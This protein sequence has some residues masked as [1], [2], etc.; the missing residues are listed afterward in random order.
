MVVP[1]LAQVTPPSWQAEA[2]FYE[3]F[4]RSF[5]DSDG[6]GIGD[7]QGILSQLDYLNDGDSTT[8]DDLGITGIWLMPINPS[9][10]YHGYD[11]TDYFGVNPD[12]GTLSDF[13]AL[14]DGCHERG[15]RVI[16]DFVGNHSSSGHPDFVQ[17]SSSP[18]H[19]KR[20]WFVWSDVNPGGD[21]H[22]GG[23]GWYYGLF[24]SGM[25]DWNVQNPAV[26]DVHY[27]VVDHWLAMGVDGFRYDAVKHLVNEGGT[28]ENH[29]GTFDYLEA[30]RNHYQSVNPE[31]ICVG[32][33]WTGSDVIAQYGPP[34]LDMCFEFGLAGGLISSVNS[35]NGGSFRGALDFV[36]D[37]HQAGAYAPFLT[38]HDQDRVMSMLGGDV[39][40]AKLAAGVLL[41]LPGTPFLY[42]GEEIGMTGSGSHPAVRTP[43]QWAPGSQAGFTSGTPWSAVQPDVNAANVASQLGDAHSLLS[44]YREFI[45][46]RHAEPA[47]QRGE[48]VTWDTDMDEAVAFLRTLGDERLLVVHNFSGAALNDVQV[49][50]NALCDG[51]YSVS[52]V[53][54]GTDLGQAVLTAG[55][56][57]SLPG[58]L[59]PHATHVFRLQAETVGDACAVPLTVAV[60]QHAIAPLGLAH[61]RYRIDGGPETTVAMGFDGVQ[62]WFTHTVAVPDGAT[63]QWRFQ[64]SQNPADVET[65][66]SG[67]GSDFG[68]GF[69]E[70]SIT[71]GSSPLSVDRVCFSGCSD[72]TYPPQQVTL[73][74]DLG[75][76]P[77]HPDGVH[78]A[79]DFQGWD[80]AGT[81]MTDE[82]G[83]VFSHTL[84]LDVG[85][86]ILYK[87]INGAA[88]GGLEEQELSGCGVPNGIGGWNR[89][90][91]VTPATGVLPAVC[92]EGCAPCPQP[93]EYVLQ[94]FSVD[95]SF[96]M[97]HP[98]GVFLAWNHPDSTLVPLEYGFNGIWTAVTHLLEGQFVAFQFR[99]GTDA[100]SLPI[101]CG[102]AG[103][104][105]RGHLVGT[106][107]EV[108]LP[109][110][111]ECTSCEVH[112]GCTYTAAL[113]FDPEALFD[114]G[115]CA[116]AGCTDPLA[117]NHMPMATV[118]DGTCFYSGAQCGPGTVLDAF[119]QCIPDPNCVVDIDGD[120]QVGVTDILLLLGSFGAVCPN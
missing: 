18:T 64:S 33:A 65:V 20:D 44:T 89:S 103:A 98:G 19:P 110:W 6:D 102:G 109:C 50:P 74:V 17:S 83:G 75:D 16:V 26:V 25:P 96:E 14:L 112:G 86:T 15:I 42:Y 76:L 93:A 9:P 2:T 35:G 34:F 11:V 46:L 27:D 39:A 43:M 30:F 41:T 97:E 82:G 104:G 108:V 99:N 54:L 119:G 105:W 81:P 51:L 80:P 57:W 68:G 52:D 28:Y 92:F 55:T 79:G 29:P 1:T 7:F 77:P 72:C 60:D 120:G 69:N 58:V 40:K 31:A 111:N 73:R 47:L 21:W 116:Y 53:R 113:N 48:T 67:C 8:T 63:V 4:V 13:Q 5:K 10:S 115:T 49:V 90:L 3:I 61:L 32:E 114:N 37:V 91:T 95:M 106:V 70:R 62:G 84:S 71:V 22:W 66:P 87:F 101:G 107:A 118:E 59:A 94:T 88:W 36:L 85:Q 23:N 56:G 78:V 24:W 117:L 12:Y 45:H 100:E 38:N